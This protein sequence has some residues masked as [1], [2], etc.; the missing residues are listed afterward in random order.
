M[1]AAAGNVHSI[2]AVALLIIRLDSATQISDPRLFYK[3]AKM[4]L[5]RAAVVLKEKP[6]T[7]LRKIGKNALHVL[8]ACIHVWR[9]VKKKKVW[10]LWS[11]EDYRVMVG[12]SATGN[13]LYQDSINALFGWLKHTHTHTL[14]MSGENKNCCL[15][16]RNVAT[17]LH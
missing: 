4:T 11:S 13:A 1:G 5:P 7:E 3:A 8:W 17:G 12:C 10:G 16:G 14:K 2:R 15:W 9:A 6:L